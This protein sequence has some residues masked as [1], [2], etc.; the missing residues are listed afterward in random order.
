MIMTIMRSRSSKLKVMFICIYMFIA[1]DIYID[2]DHEWFCGIEYKK[3]MIMIIMII[4][5]ILQLKLNEFDIS[6][7]NLIKS[8]N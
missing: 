4:L 6:V 1:A 3:I 5:F 8:G 7:G 2:H